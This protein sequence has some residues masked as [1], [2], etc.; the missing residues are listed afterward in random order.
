L[1]NKKNNNS[2][3]KRELDFELV[4]KIVMIFTVIGIIVSSILIFT[5]PISGEEYAELG[6]LTYNQSEQKY[7]AENY[8]SRIDYN[9][10]TGLSESI[11]LFIMISNHYASTKFFEIRLKIGL[12]SVLINEDIYGT[13]ETTYFMEEH[14]IKRIL[15]TDQQWGPSIETKFAFQFSEEILTKLGINEDG[16]KIIF[17][18]WEWNQTL[19]DF[20]YTGIHVYLTSLKLDLIS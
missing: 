7:K 14:W 12:Q 9:Q 5:P 18:L 3:P 8:P 4:A 17:E 2:R 15:N 20:S 11:T 6:L 10:T 16:Y 13:N 19:E 1:N